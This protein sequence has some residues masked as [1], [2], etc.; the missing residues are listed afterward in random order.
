[1]EGHS[2]RLEQVGDKILELKDKIEIKEKNPEILVK[3]L[4]SYE[5][6]MQE[7]SNSIKRPNLRLIGL[8]EG[9]EMEVKGI[10]NKFNKIITENLPHLEKVSPMQV[11]EAIRTP[12]KLDQ[13]R[14]SPWHIIKTTS[15]ENRER[16]L[17][18]VR[19]KEQITHK[20]KPIKM[21][22]DFSTETLKEGHG[23]EVFQAL[24]ENNFSPRMPYSTKLSLKIDGGIK[25]FHGKQKLKQ[26]MTTKP[27]LQK[28]LKGILYT[29]D[30]NKHNHKRMESITP[31]EKN[32]QVLR[33]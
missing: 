11:Q 22:A 19:K 1:V 32:R 12:N 24:K 8:D 23:G 29:E 9:E 3:Q 18:S 31:Y 14:T 5:R 28:T 13:K 17:K 30:K 21:T 27:P 7:L 2:S 20:G 26:Y 6:N 10:N 25:V 33:E 15:M 16:I 4:K